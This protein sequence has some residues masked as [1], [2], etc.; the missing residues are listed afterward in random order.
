M[1]ILK[2]PFHIYIARKWT[3]FFRVKIRTTSETFYI[4]Q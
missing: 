2:W 1:I 4:R 3:E